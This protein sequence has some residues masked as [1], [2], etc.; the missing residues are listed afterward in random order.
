LKSQGILEFG[1]SALILR[2]KFKCKPREQFVLRRI[3]NERIQQEF[4][5]VGI[6]FAFPTV[7]VHGPTTGA[8]AI[9]AEREAAPAS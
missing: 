4:A 2:V 5:K 7:T 9:A 8:A 3:A 6:E 1:P